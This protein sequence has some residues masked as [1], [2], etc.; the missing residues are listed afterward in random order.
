VTDDEKAADADNID[1]RASDDDWEPIDSAGDLFMR[2]TPQ[3]PHNAPTSLLE[4]RAGPAGGGGGLVRIRLGATVTH[5]LLMQIEDVLIAAD[6]ADGA[7][8]PLDE[9]D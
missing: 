4:L 3:Y 5:T 8:P 6:D 7:A 2:R 9:A 1:P